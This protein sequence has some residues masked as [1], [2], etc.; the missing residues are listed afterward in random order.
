MVARRKKRTSASGPR[1]RRLAPRSSRKLRRTDAEMTTIALLT[2]ELDEARQQQ[3]ATAD[4]L[5]VISQSGA[6]L[7]PVLDTLVAA[8]ARICLAESGFIFRLQEDGLCRVVA[9]FG[10]PAEYKDFQAR[11]PIAP[12]RGTLA[13]RTVLER[14]A[15]HIEDAAADP[16]YT[17]IEAVQLGNQRTM[18]GVPLVRDNALIGAIT[19]ARSRVE[20]FSEKEIAL[21]GTFAD[22]AVI[23]IE[24]ARLLSELRQRTTDL[25]KALDQQ[26]ATSE[27]LQGI[28]SSPGELEPVLQAILAHATRLCEASYGAMWLKEGD[29]FRNAA[30]HGTLPA[31]YI[32]Q[33]RSATV[34]RTAPLGRVAQSRKPLQIADLRE[35]QTYLDGYPLTVTAV[36]VAGI[37][38]LALVPMLKEDEFV[39][40]ISIYRKEVRPF[41][42]K[43]IEL[44]TNFAR[45][46][47]IAIENTRL[48]NELRESLQQ[49]TA[50]ADVLKVISRSTFDLK[51]VLQTLVESTARLCEADQA[52]ITRQI[53]GKFFRA[54]GYGFSAEFM[55]YVR[56]VPVEPERGTA[57]GRTLLEGKI[58]HIPDVLADPDYTWPE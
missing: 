56:D 12:G 55:D 32:E 28:S 15:V 37:R 9:S 41:T 43:Q 11:N 35:D 50:T 48:L 1:P 20:A 3:A 31:A 33:W 39:G 54:E 6:K 8:A 27:V 40:G 58:T 17:R 13:G 49:Q 38:T 19:L 51:T 4:V 30:F 46:A 45:Q 26:T 14:R 44:V 53:G 22:Q 21:V 2:R 16:E 57:L 47:V 24:N 18:L 7:G 34:G 23:A 10:I 36:D 25:S 42:D 29:R 52:T 5:K